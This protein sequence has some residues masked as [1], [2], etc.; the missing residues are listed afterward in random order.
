MVKMVYL[1]FNIV[2]MV[3]K[4]PIPLYRIKVIIIIIIIIRS[5][6]SAFC[7][8]DDEKISKGEI[9]NG[10]YYLGM[11]NCNIYFKN[12]FNRLI[13]N[14]TKINVFPNKMCICNT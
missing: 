13:M 8:Q 9:G 6:I 10:K 7:Y 14:I 2:N 5:A 3:S 4:K 12:N 1:Q 11:V